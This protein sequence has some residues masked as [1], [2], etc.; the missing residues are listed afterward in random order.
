MPSTEAAPLAKRRVDGPRRELKIAIDYED[1]AWARS[2]IRLHPAGFQKTYPTRWINSAYFDS[3]RLHNYEE[4]VATASL[5][6]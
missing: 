2:M 5:T 6:I 1:L 3:P 4:N